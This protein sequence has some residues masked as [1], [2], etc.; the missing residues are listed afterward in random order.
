M[1]KGVMMRSSTEASFARWLESTGDTW[2]YEEKFSGDGGVYKVDFRARSPLI[3]G[4][5]YIETKPY[6]DDMPAWLYKNRDQVNGWLDKMLIIRESLPDV[7][8]ALIPWDDGMDRPKQWF[9]NLGRWRLID[10][11]AGARTP[12]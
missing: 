7:P 6:R 12:W 8:L 11:V 9:L 3:N 5:V 2:K 1:H 10:D 4:T